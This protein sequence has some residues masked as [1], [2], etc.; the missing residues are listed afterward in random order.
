MD[1]LNSARLTNEQYERFTTL[2][3]EPCI[4]CGHIPAGGVYHDTIP[5]C[6]ECY[7]D[8]SLVK[9]LQQQE[10]EAQGSWIDVALME[11]EKENVND[12]Q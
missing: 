4:S 8:D 1:G 12:K 9:L 11:V 2:Q 10:I 3:L 7:L 5:C 6:I